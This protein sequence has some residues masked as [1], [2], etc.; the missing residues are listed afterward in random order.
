[1]GKYVLRRAEGDEPGVVVDAETVERWIEDVNRGDD[2]Q[3]L[4]NGSVYVAGRLSELLDV[5]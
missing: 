1:M 4:V 3:A 5:R 2:P